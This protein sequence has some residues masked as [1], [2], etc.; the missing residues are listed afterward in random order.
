MTDRTPGALKIR[1]AFHGKKAFVAYLMAGDPGISQT[2][3][4]ILTMAEAGA[5]LIEIGIPFSDP[6]AEGETIQQANLRAFASGTNIHAIFDMLQSIQG[7]IRIP[8]VF[9]TYINPVLNYGYD[10]FFQ[11]CVQC[12]VCGIIIPD[13]PFEEQDEINAHTGKYGVELV[14]LVAPTSRERVARIAQSAEGFIYLISSLGVTGVRSQI[15]T[16]ISQMTGEIRRHTSIPVAVG[17]GIHTPEQA[18]EISRY[19]DGVIVG[20]AIVD[21]I[22]KYGARGAVPQLTE[23]VRAMSAAVHSA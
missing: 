16:D 1:D 4:Y 3:E 9:M 7:E 11:K 17:F 10:L 22:G 6:I 18:H 13:L 12:G 14:T 20:S 15:T 5:D 19:A 23:Y 21:I 2:R 8:L